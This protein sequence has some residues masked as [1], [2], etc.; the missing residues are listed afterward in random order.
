MNEYGIEFADLIVEEFAALLHESGREAVARNLVLIRD[1][2]AR[3]FIE[4]DDLP[5]HAKEG[6]REMA[7]FLMKH[8]GAVRACLP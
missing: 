6:R 7:R 4:W 8:A 2:F 1:E 5:E 3:P